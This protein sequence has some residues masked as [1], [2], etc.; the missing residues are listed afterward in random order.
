MKLRRDNRLIVHGLTPC[1]RWGFKFTNPDRNLF[2]D[3]IFGD[4]Y[5]LGITGDQKDPITNEYNSYD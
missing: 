3:A 2:S 1:F 5:P 4:I